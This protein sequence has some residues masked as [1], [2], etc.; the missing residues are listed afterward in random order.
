MEGN[1][2][3]RNKLAVFDLDGTLFDTK[4]VNYAAYSEALDECRIPHEIDYE[5]YCDFCNGN[6]YKVF[7][8]RIVKKI[9]EPQMEKVHDKKKKLYKKYLDRAE[10]ND[11]LF[12]LIELIKG[13]YQI[14]VVTT[15]SRENTEE[16]LNCFGVKE[17]FDFIITQEDVMKT[18]PSPECFEKAMAMA[19]A[20]PEDTIIFE[21]SETGL[22]AAA[23]SGAKYV[24][25][26]GYN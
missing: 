3:A 22:T 12:S 20:S 16:I 2:T 19:G 9:T 17:L 24:K 5:F 14:A 23:A 13:K 10:K 21:D 25:V 7:L 26:Y 15:A 11:H 4:N 18:K 1:I 6:N 8:P